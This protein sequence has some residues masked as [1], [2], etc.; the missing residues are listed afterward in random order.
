MDE[1]L[2]ARWNQIVPFHGS[3]SGWRSVMSGVPQG[4]LLGPVLFSVFTN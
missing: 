2:V 4:S 3:L 1:E